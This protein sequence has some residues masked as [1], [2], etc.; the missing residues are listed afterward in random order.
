MSHNKVARQR[1][2]QNENYLILKV[3]GYFGMKKHSNFYGL[4]LDLAL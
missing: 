2:I 4:V 3:L 1:I